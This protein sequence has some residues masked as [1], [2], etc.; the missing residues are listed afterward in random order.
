MLTQEQAA[1]RFGMTLAQAHKVRDKAAKA[2]KDQGAAR[3]AWHSL[4]AELWPVGVPGA[5]DA[6]HPEMVRFRMLQALADGASLSDAAAQARALAV[7][8]GV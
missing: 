7:G 4:R 1:A 8:G 5:K 3:A 6:P 2:C